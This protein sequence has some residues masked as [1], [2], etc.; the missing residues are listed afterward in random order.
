MTTE[1]GR[2]LPPTSPDRFCDQGKNRISLSTA[3]TWGSVSARRWFRACRPFVGVL[4]AL[5]TWFRCVPCSSAFQLSCYSN[6]WCVLRLLVV[7]ARRL[8]SLTLFVLYV[9]L[10]RLLAIL[11]QHRILWWMRIPAERYFGASLSFFSPVP[12]GGP[13]TFGLLLVG[14]F[15][16][17][18]SGGRCACEVPGHQSRNRWYVAPVLFDRTPRLSLTDGRWRSGS[19]DLFR[20]D[21]R[22]RR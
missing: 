16:S 1:V 4:S 18:R 15:F 21:H 3:N 2:R 11:R 12:S 20:G 8:R 10:S 19:L 13:P 6:V 17:G 7:V 5:V 22:Q 14:D 9:Y